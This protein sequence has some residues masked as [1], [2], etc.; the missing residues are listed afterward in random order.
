M[1]EPDWGAL[2]LPGAPGVSMLWTV[3]GTCDWGDALI[4][5]LIILDM[6]KSFKIMMSNVYKKQRVKLIPTN[7]EH[8]EI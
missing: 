7:L 3:G 1:I 5:P 2:V 6:L 8:R 4:E